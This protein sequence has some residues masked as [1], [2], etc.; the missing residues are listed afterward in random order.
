MRRLHC[1]VTGRVQGV[2]FRG[3][4]QE[5]MKELGVRGWVRNLAD[6]RVEALLEGDDE[7][8]KRALEFLDHGPRGALVSD[9][10]VKESADSAP[11]AGFEIK[12]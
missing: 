2:Y 5:R 6:G 12:R 4:T 9:V 10:E 3:A 7:S 1:W 8:L 11:L